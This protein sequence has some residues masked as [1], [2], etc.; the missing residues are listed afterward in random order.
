MENKALR[1]IVGEQW[2]K[3][4]KE[5]MIYIQGVIRGIIMATVDSEMN[6]TVRSVKIDGKHM[7][8]V[9]TNDE[10]IEHITK[11]IEEHY[12]GLCIFSHD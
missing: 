2:K 7:F 3:C 5:S 12:P 6:K 4:G 9:L 11:V 10:C 8:K 1:I